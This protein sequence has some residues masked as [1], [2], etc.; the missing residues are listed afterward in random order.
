MGLSKCLANLLMIPSWVDGT[1]RIQND[2]EKGSVKSN[3]SEEVQQ[4]QVQNSS[5]EIK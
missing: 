3:Q 1:A 5:L 4:R 2:L